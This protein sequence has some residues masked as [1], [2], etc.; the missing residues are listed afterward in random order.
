M[1]ETLSRDLA[2]AA[3][4]LSR[5]PGFASAVVLTMAL[6]IGGTTTMFTAVNA[7]FL[8][9]LPYPQ[10][11]RVTM[12]WQTSKQSRRVPVSMLDSLDWT[13]RNRAFDHMA[14]FGG[15]TVNVT[16]GV[17]PTRVPVGY[18]N[19][20]FFGALGVAPRI[21]RTFNAD[22]LLGHG[23]SVVISDGLWRRAFQSD[24]KVLTRTLSL[25]GI[26]YPVAGVMPPGFAYPDQAEAWLPLP[27]NDGTG[28]S[29]HNYRVIARLKP[30][31]SL[32]QA[33]ADMESVAAGLAREYPSD[34]GDFGVTVVPLRRDLLGSSGPILL[35][36][37]GAVSFVLL[38]ACANVANLLLAR[39]LARRG[40]ATVRLALG[41]NRLA[42]IRP[43]VLE[44]V[45]LSL[46]GGA[47]GL[48]LA[49]AGSRFLTGL[50]PDQVLDLDRLHVDG[51]VV[52]FTFLVALTVGFFCGLI[53]ALRASRQDLRVALAAGGRGTTEGR[54][55]MRALIAAEV[56]VAFVLLI[57]AGLLLRSAW[58]L[59]E[60]DPGFQPHGVTILRFAMGGLPSSR[61][62][63]P[64]WR[65]RFFSQLLDRAATVPGVRQVGAVNELPLADGGSNGTLEL[66]SLAGE[67]PGQT[68]TAD[69]RL[70]GGHYLAALGI[71]LVS[72]Q[73]LPENPRPEGPM[74][75]LINVRLARDLGGIQK[76]L[77]RR[78]AMPG[79]DGVEEKATIVGIVGD[80]RHRGM[81]VDPVPEVYFPF[82]QRPLRTWTMS[83]V[84]RT[85]GPAEGIA[86]RMRQ[87][88]KALDPGLPVEMQTMDG[89]LAKNLAQA[90]FRARL[91]AGFAATAL[92]LA[93]VG[94]F[95][96]VAYAVRRR[97]R[98]V[99]IRMA[100]GADRGA[101]LSL[102]LREGM[103]PVGLGMACGLVAGLILTRL[104]ASLVF[105]VN[106]TDP[107]TFLA[108]ALVL[109]ITALVSTYFPAQ[110]ATQVDPVEALRA[111]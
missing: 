6:G 100:M 66:E 9:P 35:L 99:G 86:Q 32:T 30:G 76:A 16:S 59:G 87:E 51:T 80:V 39:S 44:S 58:R 62:N 12:V 36:L 73:P 40:E 10:A 54:R 75:A 42:L 25:E 38:I 5:A 79:M 46:L 22:E 84:A 60:I 31:V 77:G 11:D 4:S 27:A 14:T 63:D 107:A 55:G 90:R 13:V 52:F 67:N 7:A 1:V 91:L 111:E 70:A 45:L 93:S 103:L 65:S 2:L 71:P 50:A 109:G 15:S 24:P 89:V 96:V 94:I 19:G 47:L 69:Y 43:F 83:V 17:T 64:Q 92:L 105:Q 85:A 34:D 41:A 48:L 21:G 28:R 18:V 33:Q 101:V 102:V 110:W 97:H 49:A 56:A 29:A 61:Y 8:K 106:V 68:R 3:R 23:S 78:I 82:T 104:L 53:P 57:G 81:N 26:P 108:V 88:A 72:G 98:E 95:G 20:G 74:V 37:L